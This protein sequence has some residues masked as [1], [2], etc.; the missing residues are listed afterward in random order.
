MQ[1]LLKIF[2]NVAA[3]NILQ[4][5]LRVSGNGTDR[6]RGL[7]VQAPTD[8]DRYRHLPAQAGLDRTGSAP[9]GP[10]AGTRSPRFRS[11]LVPPQQ[12]FLERSSITT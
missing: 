2:C 3:I 8:T 1:H 9:T 11:I 5:S 12:P 10:G 7:P 4:R 6:H